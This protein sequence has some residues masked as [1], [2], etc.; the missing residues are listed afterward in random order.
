MQHDQPT[1]Q[2]IKI[3]ASASKKCFGNW[4]VFGYAFNHMSF[5]CCQLKRHFD[6]EL[7]PKIGIYTITAS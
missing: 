1:E 5:N 4:N 2:T 7:D 3:M 6:L